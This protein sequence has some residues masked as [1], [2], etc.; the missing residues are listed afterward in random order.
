MKKKVTSKN[1]IYDYILVPDELSY[2]LDGF[3]IFEYL[4]N[5][6]VLYRA[7][8]KHLKT[9]NGTASVPELLYNEKLIRIEN[10]NDFRPSNLDTRHS[11]KKT[12]ANKNSKTNIRGIFFDTHA[13]KYRG[14]FMYKGKSYKTKRYDDL[15]ITCIEY[16]NLKNKILK[17]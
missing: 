11:I 1:A 9:S 6:H 14:E 4:I 12:K 2:K 15:E 7:Y 8:S 3:K 10:N 16:Q 17:G 13:N 5:G